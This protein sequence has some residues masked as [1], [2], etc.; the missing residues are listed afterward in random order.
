MRPMSRDDTVEFSPPGST[1][2]YT[3]A[4]PTYRQRVSIEARVMAAWGPPIGD[5]EMMDEVRTA[6]TGMDFAAERRAEIIAAA[7]AYTDA[8]TALIDAQRDHAKTAAGNGALSDELKAALAIL[9]TASD[10]V[11]KIARDLSRAWEP[12]RRKM[13]D[14][15]E[16]ACEETC[17]WVAVGVRAWSLDT[18][19]DREGDRL[20][21]GAVN[22]IPPHHLAPIADKMRE[23]ATLSEADRGNSASPSGASA[24]PVSPSAD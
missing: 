8:L 1:A 17:A 7:D 19:C 14:R 9:N 22:R 3:L 24:T 23:L 6:A 20:T 2:H 5:L 11:N 12:L 15:I 4:P 18:P 21:D 13:A 10:V 16:R